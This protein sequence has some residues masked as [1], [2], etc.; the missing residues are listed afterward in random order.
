MK[1]FTSIEEVNEVLG[2]NPTDFQ[3]AQWCRPKGD[4]IPSLL[5]PYVKS[6]YFTPEDFSDCKSINEVREIV[7]NRAEEVKGQVDRFNELTD[8][9]SAEL[10]A[11]LPSKSN[12]PK[13]GS[14]LIGLSVVFLACGCVAELNDLL[15]GL[16]FN[17]PLW[18]GVFAK[19]REKKIE[20]SY[21]SALNA[22][23]KSYRDYR[24]S[25]LSDSEFTWPYIIEVYN[26]KLED[27]KTKVAIAKAAAK[28]A[29]D[30][31]Y[32]KRMVEQAVIRSVIYTGTRTAMSS[33]T[34]SLK[35][36]K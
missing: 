21:E 22:A 29:S 32:R 8:N 17:I 18:I 30:A 31:E 27:E 5:A 10:Y 24:A 13:L 11:S 36:K 25:L 6:I 28:A 20:K 14:Y 34:R 26:N 3:L 1:K 19:I 7:I 9:K 33:L 2:I 35:R 23:N 12:N 16:M 15:I 4:I